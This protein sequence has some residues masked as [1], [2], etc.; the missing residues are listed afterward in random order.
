VPLKT[1]WDAN[2]QITIKNE[3]AGSDYGGK[4]DCVEHIKSIHNQTVL[5]KVDIKKQ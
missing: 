5:F 1:F 3:V 4:Q 2:T